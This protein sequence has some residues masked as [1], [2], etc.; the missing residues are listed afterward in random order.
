MNQ[1]T[2][3]CLGT[4]YKP[5]N[6][7]LERRTKSLT[8]VLVEIYVPLPTGGKKN[9]DTHECLGRNLSPSTYG[10]KDESSHLRV[11]WSNFKVL[12]TGGS[13]NQATSK[14]LGSKLNSFYPRV[15]GR[16]KSLTSVL[17]EI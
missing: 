11:P 17:L 4:K 8:S 5:F 9:Q 15:D 1:A 12:P 13:T 16:T 7:R 3:K 14:C 6:P 10:W 2:S